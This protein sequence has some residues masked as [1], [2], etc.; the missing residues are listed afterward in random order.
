MDRF[1]RQRGLVRQDEVA[2]LKI[3]IR[4]SEA[5][6]K[7]FIES[8]TL[9]AEHLGVMDFPVDALRAE[10][11]ILWSE[12]DFLKRYKKLEKLENKARVRTQMF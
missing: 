4:P 11:T 1:A 5:M 9:M 3:A 2:D 6:P 10:Y 8:L 12:N 7:V